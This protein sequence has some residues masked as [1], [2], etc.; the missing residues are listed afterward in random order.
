M[1]EFRH[2]YNRRCRNHD[3]RSRCIYMITMLKSLSAPLFAS[4]TRDRACAK[5]VPVVE[6]YPAGRIVRDSLIRLSS[7]YPELRVLRYVIMPDHIHF[8][9]F[10][11]EPTRLPLGSMMAAFKSACSKKYCAAL[12][13]SP[14]TTEPFSLFQPGF[15]DRIAF[16]AGA[17]DAFYNYIA[18]NPRRYLVRK[19]C[20]EYFFH[21]LQIEVNG[22]LCGIYGN[23]FLLD[24][25]VKS[26]VKISRIKE[27]TP[28][29][30]TKT[31]EWEES[32]R[33]GGV[34]VSPFI[35]PE[36]KIYRDKAIENGNGIILI[37]NYKF[38]DRQKP[39]KELFDLCAEGRMLIVSTEEFSHAPKSIE[40]LNARKLNC[41]AAAIARIQPGSVIFRRRL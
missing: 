13:E 26:A 16:R 18:D 32:I 8:E 40:Y 24:N 7:D 25:P 30:E 41:I 27:R 19:H 2:S 1:A 15:N 6:L 20:P 37:V 34:L 12:P 11:T 21:K 38:S 36:E 4:I 28:N 35:N 9:V 10:V 14:A 3:Y 22:T 31:A 29:L 23:I 5:I 33:C 39:Y 17:K